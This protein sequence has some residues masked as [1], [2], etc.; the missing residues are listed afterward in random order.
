MEW[1]LPLYYK[2]NL[3][4]ERALINNTPQVNPIFKAINENNKNT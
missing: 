1:W 3:T 4:V 2:V